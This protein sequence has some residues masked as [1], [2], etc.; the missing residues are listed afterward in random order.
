MKSRILTT[1]ALLI[2]ITLNAL[3]TLARPLSDMAKLNVQIQQ[4]VCTQKW[5]EAVKI[6]DQM[7]TITPSS[8]Q[9]QH[10]E[11]ETY[12]E[13]MQSLY[14]SKANVPHWSENCFANS[15]STPTATANANSDCNPAYPDVCLPNSGPDLNCADIPYNNIK[16][17]PSD[18]YGFD[19]DGDGIGCER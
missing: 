7:I 5:G 14:N 13:R 18:P 1:T 9:T 15:V 11:L 4:A 2:T 3:P 17:L 10:K 12:R 19:G 8:N 6:V 16:V